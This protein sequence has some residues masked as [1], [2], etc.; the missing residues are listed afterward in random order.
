MPL[1]AYPKQAE[2]NRLVSKTKIYAHAKPTRRVRELFVEQVEELTW[3]YKLSPETI[4]L[5]A[6][7]GINE[8]QIFAIALKVP[9]LDA[10]VLDAIDRAIPFPLVFEI[11]REHEVWSVASYKRPSEADS[12]KWVNEATFET[13]PQP[14]NV[15]RLP[16]P[17]A[18][19]LLGLYD[20]I[21]RSHIPL[22]PRVAEGIAEHVARFKVL[23]ASKRMKQQLEARL[24]QEKQFNRRVELNAQ[25]RALTAEMASL[26]HS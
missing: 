11:A 16:L 19:D 3:K 10:S 2:V 26:Q 7:N 14:A 1:F 15:E 24:S 4:N 12:A 18:L 6:R 9:H 20:Q 8:I 25:L 5:P 23:E 17:V 22:L 21:I 13:S